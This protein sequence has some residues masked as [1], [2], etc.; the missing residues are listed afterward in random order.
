MLLSIESLANSFDEQASNKLHRVELSSPAWRVVN[1]SVMGGLSVGTT[2]SA[3][4][5]FIFSGEI[6]TENNGGFTSVYLP[7]QSIPEAFDAISVRMKGDGNIYQLRVRSQVD[8]YNLTY[9]SDFYTQKNLA[10][11]L[12]FRLSDFQASF[13]GRILSGAPPLKTHEIT[14]VG[15]LITGKERLNFSLSV[16]EIAF[17]SSKALNE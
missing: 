8:G 17:Y 6:S 3:D 11:Q 5:A 7:V 2:D 10:Q 1:D 14:H 4:Q 13:R 16:D 15:F 9:K 12:S